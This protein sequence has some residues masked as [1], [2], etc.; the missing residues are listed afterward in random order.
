MRSRL[1]GIT[2]LALGLTLL[3]GVAVVGANGAA[4]ASPAYA[5]SVTRGLGAGIDA[6]APFRLTRAAPSAQTA[7]QD[8]ACASQPPDAAGNPNDADT[9][10]DESTAADATEP[11]GEQAATSDAADTDTLQCGDQ[12]GADGTAQVGSVSLLS[13]KAGTNA[14]VAKAQQADTG[15]AE[16]ATETETA[17]VG[18]ESVDGVNLD[19]QG[20]H[21]GNNAG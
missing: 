12:T 17:G 10:Q 14:D 11:T 5:S 18:D 2:G 21:E 19:Q 1:T 13:A 9:I 15:A 16:S 8:P 3:G 7:P 4:A 20:E 6:G